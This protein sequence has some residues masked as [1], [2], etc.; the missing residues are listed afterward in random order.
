MRLGIIS[1]H[2]E[3][4]LAGE[5][6]SLQNLLHLLR[7]SKLE[8]QTIVPDY[9]RQVLANDAVNESII[10]KISNVY[11]VFR[12]LRKWNAGCDVLQVQLPSPAFAILADI[13]KYIMRM[14]IIVIFES[15]L[16]TADNAWRVIL[17][18]HRAFRFYLVR[19][20]FNNA[21]ISR[22]SSFSAEKYIV[23]S[24]YQKEQLRAM[25]IREE[26]V[27]IIPN[28]G[29]AGNTFRCNRRVAKEF[30]KFG[31]KQVITYIGHFMHYKGVHV[32]MSAF[33]DVVRRSP[34]SVL[35]LAW[36]G[37]GSLEWVKKLTR[38]FDIDRNTILL[39]T[40]N[41]AE[42]LSTTDVFILPYLFGFGTICFPNLVLEAFAT[43]VPLI[44]TD[45]KPL[46][47]LITNNVH[48]L[49]VRAG[50]PAALASAIVNVLSNK[51]LGRRMIESQRKISKDRLSPHQLVGKYIQ[52]Y[53]R[54]LNDENKH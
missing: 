54:V 20:V 52:V 43:G 50:D 1:F 42:L 53:K 11:R 51:A 29:T 30:F 38:K 25:G 17:T 24:Y 3:Y 47:E 21:L 41:V 19:L 37:Y 33:S 22:L 12:K 27:E 4:S 7:E 9:E 18:C 32:L 13:V 28:I 45:V 16:V 15:N 34:D 36:S 46:N 2:L 39:G 44:V 14:P 49:V 35:V 23:S 48:G 8:I 31:N 6:K 5:T 40:V 26:K 10:R